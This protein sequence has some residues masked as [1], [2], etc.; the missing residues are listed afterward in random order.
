MK[1]ATGDSHVIRG[2]LLYVIQIVLKVDSYIVS[3][4]IY[5]GLDFIKSLD[6]TMSNGFVPFLEIACVSYEGSLFGVHIKCD[7][8]SEQIINSELSFGFHETPGSLKALAVS[9]AGKYLICGGMDEYI[10]VFDLTKRRSLG[11]MSG[12]TGCVTTLEFVGEKFVISASEDGTM[13]IWKVQGWQKLHILGGHKG[14]V[15]DFAI[16]PSGKLCL[17][18]SKDNTLKIWNLVH[19]RCAFTRRLKGPAQKVAWHQK[20]DYYLLVVGNEV[21]I[22][23]S[24]G[25]NECSGKVSLSTRVNQACFVDIGAAEG[26]PGVQQWCKSWP[27]SRPF[28]L[29][30]R[31]QAARHVVL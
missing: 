30:G 19:G 6:R 24:S 3:R 9:G 23:N 29:P 14:P 22:Y 28:S 4:E 15:N 25:N 20:E 17:S 26:A 10:R 5:I 2:V 13:I 18:V 21:Q 1:G 7:S 8:A 31:E 16:H 11:E 12:H 27:L